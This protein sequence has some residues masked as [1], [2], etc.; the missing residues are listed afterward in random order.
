VTESDIEVLNVIK[1]SVLL[2]GA[3]VMSSKLTAGNIR[4]TARACGKPQL[5]F[6]NAYV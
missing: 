4:F 2:S 5:K 6:L 1:A 3:N